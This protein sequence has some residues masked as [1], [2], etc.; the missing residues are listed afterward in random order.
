MHWC[1]VQTKPL[2]KIKRVD[3]GENID[4]SACVDSGSLGP[5]AEVNDPITGDTAVTTEMRQSKHLH[6]FPSSLPS[7]GSAE[8]GST[9][10]ACFCLSTACEGW[11]RWA[12]VSYHSTTRRRCYKPGQSQNP[13]LYLEETDS[14][15]C[16]APPQ[17]NILKTVV[18]FD[19]R[20]GE[21][22]MSLVPYL[23]FSFSCFRSH[24]SL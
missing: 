22:K 6:A 18:H 4:Y 1:F 7:S 11:G 16:P 10:Q 17:Q 3:V 9:T 24:Y 23:F 8:K 19:Q 15:P 12:T 5:E 13:D 14:S 20:K 21:T 2:A